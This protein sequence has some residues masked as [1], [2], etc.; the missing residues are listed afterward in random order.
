MMSSY[1][2]SRAGGP[3]APLMVEMAVW[4]HYRADDYGVAEGRFNASA[5]A[6]WRE[7]MIRDGLI[8]MSDARASALY[9]ATPKLTDYVARLC[10]VDW[11]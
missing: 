4:Y 1:V 10:Q 6:G 9:V 8:V 5:V 3:V 2:R 7:R 11:K